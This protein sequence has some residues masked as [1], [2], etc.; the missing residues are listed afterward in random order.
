MLEGDEESDA[1]NGCQ[2][3]REPGL[4]I[5]FVYLYLYYDICICNIIQW[6]SGVSRTYPRYK[7]KY[8]YI[9]D[10]NTDIGGSRTWP[11]YRRRRKNTNL[12]SEAYT[13]TDTTKMPIQI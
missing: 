11:R 5:V 10:A 7:Y 13:N 2:E 3:V 6:V 8:K 12:D 1:C 9:S 4:D